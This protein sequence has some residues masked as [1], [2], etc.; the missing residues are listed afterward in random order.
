MPFSVVLEVVFSRKK[1]WTDYYRVTDTHPDDPEYP[2][3]DVLP[4]ELRMSPR[5]ALVL[6]LEEKPVSA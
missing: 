4:I 3:L 5:H 1:F 6:Q 2:E